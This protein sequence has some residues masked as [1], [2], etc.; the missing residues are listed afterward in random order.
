MR[1]NLDP[2]TRAREAIEIVCSGSIER[3]GEYYSPDMVDHVN[4]DI[5]LGH[6]GLME[7]YRYYK[8]VFDGGWRFEVV[9]QITEADRVASRWVLHGRC[10]GRAVDLT[11][12]TLSTVNEDGQVREDFGHADTLSLVKQ[13]GVLRSVRLGVEVLIGRVKLPKPAPP[14]LTWS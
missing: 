14:G 6:D 9:D 11:G 2:T 13:L 10:R 1:E 4:D 3:L 8:S 5:H 12:I 7:S